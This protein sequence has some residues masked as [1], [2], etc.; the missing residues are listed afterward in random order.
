[1][2][3]RDVNIIKAFKRELDL[4][5]RKVRDKSKYT[6]KVKHKHKQSLF[7]FYL[8]FFFSSQM[9][10]Y[11]FYFIQR[12]LCYTIVQPSQQNCLSDF[13]YFIYISIQR[14]ALYFKFFS[15][16][17]KTEQ[18]VFKHLINGLTTREIATTLGVTTY[19]I[20]HHISS[21]LR[22]FKQKTVT[23]LIVWYYKDLLDKE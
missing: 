18:I 19:A 10:E 11:F 14:T 21:I 17:T 3:P 7:G 23:K 2:K 15:S 5:T 20:K 6:R 22:V 1:M 8:F 9:I 4:S 13:S 12:K 16:L